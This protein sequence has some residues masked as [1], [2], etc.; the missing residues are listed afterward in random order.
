MAN[1]RMLRRCIMCQKFFTSICSGHRVCRKCRKH[2]K[3]LQDTYIPAIT[4]PEL[5]AMADSICSQSSLDF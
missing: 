5:V 3:R 1:I 4:D 2:W